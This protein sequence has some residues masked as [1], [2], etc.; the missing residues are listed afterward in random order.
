M[1]SKFPR[2][3]T[4]LTK[5]PS[6]AFKVPAG[7]LHRLLGHGNK[8]RKLLQVCNGLFSPG[9]RLAQQISCAPLMHVQRQVSGVG[10]L[11]AGRRNAS[12]LNA[13]TQID[14]TRNDLLSVLRAV[15]QGLLHAGLVLLELGAHVNYLVG[16][17]HGRGFVSLLVGCDDVATDTDER[18]SGLEER[19]LL[20]LS[21]VLGTRLNAS[22]CLSEELGLF[23][24]R[25]V[26]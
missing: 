14:I 16:V 11:A 2:N 1:L 21:V 15:G 13:S 4:V 22:A 9:G 19:V 5:C 20:S 25:I 10:Q 17:S 8:L 24:A 23:P 26:A 6:L 3:R 7:L 18:L 12:S